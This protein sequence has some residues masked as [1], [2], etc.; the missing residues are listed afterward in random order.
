MTDAIRNCSANET[1]A[2]CCVDVGTVMD[3]TDCSASWSGV[4]ADRQ[5][6]EAMLAELSAKAR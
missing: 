4:F 2:C 3:N 5:A 1:A 6:A